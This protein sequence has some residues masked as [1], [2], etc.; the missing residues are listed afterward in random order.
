MATKSPTFAPFAQ[1]QDS[2][3]NL[4]TGAEQLLDSFRKEA[5]KLLSHKDRRKVVDSLLSQAKALPTD[6]QR[7]AGKTLKAFETRAEK[8]LSE[9]QSHAKRRIGWLMSRFSLPSKHEVELLAKRLS[10]LEKKVD[11]LLS[12]KQ[13][14]A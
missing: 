2:I 11:D 3:R 7:K 6:L 13:G 5:G 12:A 14:A 8:L 1:V 4:Q 10:S 9:A